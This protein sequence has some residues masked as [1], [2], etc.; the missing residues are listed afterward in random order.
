MCSQIVRTRAH[1]RVWGTHD[2]ARSGFSLVAF[3]C[4]LLISNSLL[5]LPNAASAVPPPLLFLAVSLAAEKR[6]LFDQYGE[7][8]LKQGVPNGKGGRAGGVGGGYSF[9]ANPE[10]LFADHFG[11]SSPFADFFATSAAQPLFHTLKQTDKRKV[12]AQ[13][14]NLYVS[15]EE[16]YAGASKSHKLLRKRLGMDGRTLMLEEKIL[17]LEIGAGW[18]EGTRLTF[19]REGDEEPGETSETGDVI[20]V[21]RTKPHPRFTRRGNDLVY[22]APLTLLAALTGTTLS[23]ETLDRRVLPIAL[24]EVCAPGGSK[25]VVGEGM[26]NPKDPSSASARGNLVIEFAISFPEQLSYEQKQGIKKILAPNS[27]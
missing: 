16:L 18:K 13:E 22:T 14:I 12:A 21:L 7:R 27:A 17:K 26:P 15:L 19:A 8:G 3:L 20:F 10:E 11:T 23:I 25:I 2:A 6:A 1:T 4:P 5:L 9:T 24:N